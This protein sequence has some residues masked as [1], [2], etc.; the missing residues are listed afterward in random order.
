MPVSFTGVIFFIISTWCCR[1][2]GI[3]NIP[4]KYFQSCFFAQN[5]FIFLHQEKNGSQQNDKKK[6]IC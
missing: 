1:I 3:L 2:L 4:F 6:V 5:S